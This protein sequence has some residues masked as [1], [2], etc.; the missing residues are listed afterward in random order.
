MKE[1]L[2]GRSP[3]GLMGKESKVKWLSPYLLLTWRDVLEERRQLRR[4]QLMPKLKVGKKYKRWI[5]SIEHDWSSNQWV[6]ITFV[7]LET[8]FLSVAS[9]ARRQRSGNSSLQFHDRILI[10]QGKAFRPAG[11]DES[12]FEHQYSLDNFCKNV[13]WQGPELHY[14]CTWLW[15]VVGLTKKRDVLVLWN[16]RDSIVMK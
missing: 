3:Y 5:T 12:V 8:R 7:A 16:D 1:T 13:F 14:L 4:R 15:W 6:R 10:E 9:S 2:V 11:M